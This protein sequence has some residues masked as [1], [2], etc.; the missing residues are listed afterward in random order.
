MTDR[1]APFLAAV[2]TERVRTSA[3]AAALRR[4][5]D[6]IVEGA[7]LTSTDDEH[8]P[9]G[10]TIAYERAKAWALLRQALA[11]LADLDVALARA[12]DGTAGT[13]EV[14]GGTIVIERLLALPHTRR[15]VRC[16]S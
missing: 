5:F 8:D 2:E 14:C 1:W 15:C 11:D 6:E 4:E 13:C 10:S 9:D 12:A 7:E 3:Q 16:A